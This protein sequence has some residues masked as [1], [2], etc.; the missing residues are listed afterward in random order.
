MPARPLEIEGQTWN[1]FPS[2]FVTPNTGDEFGLLFVRGDGPTTEL[3]V[4]RYA[5]MGAMSR[6]ASLAQLSDAD[7]RRLFRQSQASEHSPEA[8]YRP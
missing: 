5:P 8:G 1:V 4:T 3:R 6:E 2:G 7:L